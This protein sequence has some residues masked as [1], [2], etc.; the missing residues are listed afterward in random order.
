[1]ILRRAALEWSQGFDSEATTEAC[2]KLLPG[3]PEVMREYAGKRI[4]RA[5]LFRA[6]AGIRGAC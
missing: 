5:A 2:Q 6:V 4:R 3:I 1:M